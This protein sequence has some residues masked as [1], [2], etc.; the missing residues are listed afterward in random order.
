MCNAL[1]VSTITGAV[2]G[3]AELARLL[4]SA[5][6]CGWASRTDLPAI[7]RRCE[8]PT[9]LVHAVSELSDQQ[10]AMLAGSARMLLTAFAHP[11]QVQDIV[12]PLIEECRITITLQGIIATTGDAGKDIAA[13]AG[14]GLT[15]LIAS[16]GPQAAAICAW[17]V[18]DQPLTRVG[19]RRTS[20]A[21][22]PR[23]ANR[24]RVSRHRHTTQ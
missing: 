16:N 13:S 24:I 2:S 17:R 19:R 5:A 20:V 15:N 10:T 23:C 14:I 7:A 22:S 8:W 4:A 6:S 3:D 1:L 11:D 21:C 18:C 12:A 9:N